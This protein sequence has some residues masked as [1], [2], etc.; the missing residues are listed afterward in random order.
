M[1]INIKEKIE[2]LVER[3]TADKNLM[4]KFQRDPVKAVEG[5]LGVDLPDDVMEKLVAGVKGKISL[6]KAA[7]AVD[8]LKKLF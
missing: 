6:D 3:I 1:D 7:D 4:A 5:L 8:M 2:E